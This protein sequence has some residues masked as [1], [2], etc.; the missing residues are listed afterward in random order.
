M[1]LTTLIL[2]MQD[3]HEQLTV[4]WQSTTI[5]KYFWYADARI[6]SF[7]FALAIMGNVVIVVGN[8]FWWW[9]YPP[10]L[11]SLLERLLGKRFAPWI[12]FWMRGVALFSPYLLCRSLRSGLM[13]FSLNVGGWCNCWVLCLLCWMWHGFVK[14]CGTWINCIE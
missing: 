14:Q 6:Y 4:T 12:S 5:P 10:K 7:L 2:S 9:S 1:P 3:Q 11:L 13:I 8:L